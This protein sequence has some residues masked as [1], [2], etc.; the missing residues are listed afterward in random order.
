MIKSFLD[1]ETRELF[2][3]GKCKSLPAKIQRVAR[4]KLFQLD[5]AKVLND[6]KA[7]PGNKLEALKGNLKG[8]YSIRINRQYRIIFKFANGNAYDIAIVDYHK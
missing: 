6:L 2:V 7:P 5:K 4:R 3:K 1:K 8:F